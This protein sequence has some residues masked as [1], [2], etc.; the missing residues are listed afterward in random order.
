MV[1]GTLALGRRGGSGSIARDRQ[2]WRD[3]EEQGGFMSD[4]SGGSG[5]VCEAGHGFQFPTGYKPDQFLYGDNGPW[6]SQP[7]DGNACKIAPEVFKEGP[8]SIDESEW[9]DWTRD[10][11][12]YLISYATA[13]WG[14]NAVSALNYAQEILGLPKKEPSG[15]R[16]EMATWVANGAPPKSWGTGD[17]G[18]YPALDDARFTDMMAHG[19]LSKLLSKLDK[20]D[21]SVFAQF[22]KDLTRE[23]WKSDLTHMRA[24]RTP[25]EGEY[26]APAIALF[27]RPR[28]PAG[29]DPYHFQ[30][31]AIALYVQTTPG[32]AYDQLRIFKPSDGKAWQQAKYFALQGAL[33]RINL[34]DHTMVHFPMDAIN[35]I[36]KSLLPTSNTIFQLLK[37]HFYLSLPV[38]NSVL[39]GDYSLL[40]RTWTYPYSPYPAKGPE[41]RKLFAFYWHGWKASDDPGEPWARDRDNAFPS[42]QF[43][44]EPRDLPSRYGT[45][46]N[47]YHKPILQ[48]TTSI[49]SLMD[50]S[51]NNWKEI[52]RWADACASW[53]PGFPNGETINKNNELLAK[54]CASI[55]W[56]VA[57]VHSA[58]HWLMH[59]LFERKLP[60]PYILRDKPPEAGPSLPGLPAGPASQRQVSDYRPEAFAEWDVMPARLCDEMFFRPHN[61]TL[62]GETA[63][64]FKSLL[65]ALRG[66]LQAQVSTFHSALAAIDAAMHVQFP[67]FGIKLTPKN[68]SDKDNNCFAA[69]VQF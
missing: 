64:D 34:V 5:F 42:Y 7:T 48:F 13:N 40:N 20:P 51:E 66:A 62:L 68:Q 35:A 14:S 43:R 57:I 24:V 15:F 69:G 1:G 55:I 50:Q 30:V 16:F 53:I 63:Y 56:N 44:L 65:P 33:I 2:R 19:L 21:V 41:I 6:P 58:D 4:Q 67:E 28:M 22:M 46:L 47:A 39:E 8:H 27:S 45:F 37:P 3:K 60:T 25:L 61:T 17:K 32:C 10:L 18:Q 54:T 23:Y 29:G 11:G 26:V 12:N 59:D 9:K 36:T 38:D 49:V 31:H 52:C